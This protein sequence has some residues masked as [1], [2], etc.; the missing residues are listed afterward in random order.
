MGRRR[1]VLLFPRFAPRDS[2]LVGPYSEFSG[3]FGRPHVGPESLAGQ[4]L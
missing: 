1:D 4:S 3:T 2:V